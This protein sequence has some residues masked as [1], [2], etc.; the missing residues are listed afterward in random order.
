MSSLSNETA[1]RLHSAAIHL[2][3]GIRAADPETGL[4][5]ARLSAMSV[6]VFGGPRT[7]TELARAEQ[8][9]VPTMSA[10]VRALADDGLVRREADPDDRRSAR[11]HATAKGTRLLERARQAR[12]QTLA[13]RLGGLREDE[14]QTLARAAALI[15]R[16]FG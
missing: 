6:L 2:L 5:P 15:E 11:L 13:A 7:L 8:V 10:I 1:D 3:R 9:R 12:V 14:L 16:S 4:S